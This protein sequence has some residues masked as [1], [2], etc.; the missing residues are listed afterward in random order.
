[1]KK[2]VRALMWIGMCVT[3][4]LGG[5]CAL[6][7]L[8]GL[9]NPTVPSTS[10]AWSF[11]IL[12]DTQWTTLDDGRNPNTSAIDIINQVNQQFISKGV[13]FV[14]AV[15]DL[16]D[17]GSP[18]NEDVRAT[19]AQALYN[20]G[21]GF[22]PLRGN[23]DSSA[24]VAAEFKNLYPQTQTG[25]NNQT[26][27]SAFSV[28]TADPAVQP[29]AK[30]GSTFVVGANFSSPSPAMAGL[31]YSFDYSNARLILLD[32]FTPPD[33][34]TNSIDAQM[35][36]ITG[37]LSGRGSNT[38]AFVFGH[39]GIIT[40]NH[41]DNLFGAHPGA[42]PSGENA[43]IQGMAQAGARYYIC[44]HD[45]MHDRSVVTTTDAA[46]A[47]IDQIVCAS[48]SSKFYIPVNPSNDSVWDTP[49]RQTPIAQELNTVGYYI[50]TVDGAN[51]TV[52]F[53]SAV[54]NPAYSS[55]EYLL[56]A[57][58]AMTFNKR[59]SFGYSLAG[60]EFIIPQGGSYTAVQ[61][62]YSGSGAVTTMKILSGTNANTA[63]DPSSRP[64]SL[65]VNT[66]WLQKTSGLLSDIV[67]LWGMEYQF[68]SSATDAYTISLSF[69]FK[70][71][72]KS[73]GNTGDLGVLKLDPSGTKWVNAVAAN[74]GGTPRFV[75]GPW[76]AS[77]GLG[78]YGRDLSTNPPTAWAVVNSS[79]TFAV[80]LLD[81]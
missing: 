31:S 22:Y 12:S 14:V 2:R 6:G 20:A 79:G 81:K 34:S 19:Y 8:L 4:V 73:M 15:G 39:K 44:G 68:G 49:R 77:Y 33:G 60:K 69:S 21:I 11:G 70:T 24:A 61:D 52:D 62:S 32:Q 47:R 1:M 67:R 7:G 63:T 29:P 9:L 42:D 40:E 3:V 65:A 16:A 80:G 78:T 43:L 45:H 48:D 57:T 51:V 75:E 74:A 27:A 50:V 25:V 10:G 72:S 41:V 56:F 28:Q 46:T 5:G 59:E 76:K 71:G 23:H 18:A 54:V 55:G 35:S 30:S 36:W 13:K 17:S 58:P 38:H 64:F 53:Y 37:Q 26:P 66:G